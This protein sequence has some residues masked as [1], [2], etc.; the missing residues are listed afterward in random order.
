MSTTEPTTATSPDAANHEADIC[1]ID[2][3]TFNYG[4][5][6]ALNDVSFSASR[7]QTIALIGQSGA[8]KTTLLRIIAGMLTPTSGTVS[9]YGEQPSE[10]RDASRRTRLVGMMQQRLD[11]VPQLSARHNAEA[12]M[13]GRW[14]LW[15][16]LAGLALP[17]KHGPAED[18]LARVG[19]AG[20]G[21]ERVSKLSGGEQQRV[22]MAR[23]LVQDPEVIVADEPVA[24]L[25]PDLANELIVLLKSIAKERGRTV[26]ASVHDPRL[27]IAHFDRVIGL[28]ESDV[29]F[30]LAADEVTS[31][32]L[33]SLYERFN[34]AE[35]DGAATEMERPLWGI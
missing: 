6:V 35:R 12:G 29:Q 3:V 27:A 15:R 28:R 34:G 14:S 1:K 24:S 17:L 33:Q 10:I 30:D 7:G 18:A 21:T 23:L 25:D 2:G 26:F 5:R 31:E 11:L 22:A 8:G 13:L 16:S 9:L 20:R 19:L 4:N 32:H